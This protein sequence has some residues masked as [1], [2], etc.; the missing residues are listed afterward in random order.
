MYGHWQSDG[1]IVPANPPNNSTSVGAEAGEG[2]RPAKGK[3]NESPMPQTQGWTNGMT[4]VLERLRQAVQRERT[5]KL[6]ALYHHV[7]EIDHLR[8]TYFSLQ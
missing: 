7:Y 1:R 4:E 8:E 6:T 3:A 5:V 2:R